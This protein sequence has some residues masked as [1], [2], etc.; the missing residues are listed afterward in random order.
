VIDCAEHGNE[1]EFL[2]SHGDEY[3]DDFWDVASCCHI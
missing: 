1:R 2:G 3:E